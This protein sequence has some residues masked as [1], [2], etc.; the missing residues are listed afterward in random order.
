MELALL[1]RDRIGNRL[2]SFPE[3]WPYPDRVLVWLAPR[4]KDAVE[5]FH[6]RRGKG[7]VDIFRAVELETI[8]TTLTDLLIER[9]GRGTV[10]RI[11]EDLVATGS[12]V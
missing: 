10:R 12:K 7:M 1:C 8:D 4:F 6:D 3:G 11:L 9:V 5:A 2:S